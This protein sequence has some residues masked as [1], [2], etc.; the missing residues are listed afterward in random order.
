MAD[1]A[2]NKTTEPSHRAT[3][4]IREYTAYLTVT[5]TDNKD[6]ESYMKY[7]IQAFEPNHRRYTLS[8][9][10]IFQKQVRTRGLNR[11]KT[12]MQSRF[13]SFTMEN[14][15]DKLNST[16]IIPENQ[17][18]VVKL[19]TERAIQMLESQPPRDEGAEADSEWENHT[20]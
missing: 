7:T 13:I 14:L 3:I 5:S 15:G 9:A 16:K 18:P 19:H 8:A 4:Q 10:I 17:K 20:I 6:R 1:I 11:I 2:S 12:Q